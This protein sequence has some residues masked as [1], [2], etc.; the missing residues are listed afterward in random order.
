MDT[1]QIGN[2][3]WLVAGYTWILQV[4]HSCKGLKRACKKQSMECRGLGSNIKT[5][6]PKCRKNVVKSIK[7]RA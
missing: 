2:D 4:A 1:C 7:W 6:S 3:D 5:R